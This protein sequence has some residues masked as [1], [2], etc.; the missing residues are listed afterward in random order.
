[1][2]DF[3]DKLTTYI[4]KAIT[5]HDGEISIQPAIIAAHVI[6]QINPVKETNIVIL[7]GFNLQVRAIARKILGK[8]FD[9][10]EKKNS[11]QSEMFPG[12]QE[13][14]PVDRGGEDSEYILRGEMTIVEREETENK[15]RKTGLAFIE[16]ADALRVE[17]DHLKTSGAFNNQALK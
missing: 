8:K 10:T 17:T 3:N 12:L 2:K 4:N 16:H 11:D 5:D 6:K 1:M 7:W 15:L 14:Y 13:R 9:P